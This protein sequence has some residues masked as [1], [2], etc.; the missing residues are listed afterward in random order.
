M[1]HLEHFST[2]FVT[3]SLVPSLHWF[4]ESQFRL[5]T[6]NKSQ[7]VT[8]RSTSVY[9]SCLLN[10]P[11]SPIVCL[12]DST[13]HS[14]LIFLKKFR[15]QT[16]CFVSNF[17]TASLHASNFNSEHHSNFSFQCRAHSLTSVVVFIKVCILS[18]FITLC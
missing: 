6:M 16:G 10:I 3:S 17:P 2:V 11:L 14:P 7:A 12:F 4:S 1:G 15:P 5:L 18:F 13:A 9:A 8:N